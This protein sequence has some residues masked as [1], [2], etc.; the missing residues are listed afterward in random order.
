MT[1]ANETAPDPKTEGRN[2]IHNLTHSTLSVS[3]KCDTGQGYTIA[4]ARCIIARLRSTPRDRY[5]L[6]ARPVT[7]PVRARSR[8]CCATA[9]L[10]DLTA[11]AVAPD[12]RC[13][14]ARRFGWHIEVTS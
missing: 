5:V 8:F 1:H 7:E 4:D 13:P 2:A 6:A 3:E 10:E 9:G 11:R 12:P 14:C